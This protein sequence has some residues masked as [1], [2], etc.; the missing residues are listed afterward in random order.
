[1]NVGIA[2]KETNKI[3][4]VGIFVFYFSLKLQPIYYHPRFS[5]S[6]EINFNDIPEK[7]RN[8]WICN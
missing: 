3:V 4:H 7:I 1:M 8:I 6:Q 2:R 5:L